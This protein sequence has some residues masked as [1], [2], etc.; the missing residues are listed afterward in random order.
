MR[1]QSIAK[2][3]RLPGEKWK[4]ALKRARNI[5]KYAPK[6]DPE[7][8]NSDINKT[9][10]HNCYTYFLNLTKKSLTE[11][12]ERE[13]CQK[14]NAL[15]PQ[16]GY[17]AGFIRNKKHS[18]TNIT[19]R[20]MKDNPKMYKTTLK[21]DCEP[22][23]YMG[24]LATM[25]GSTYHYYRRDNTGY[26]SHKDGAGPAN[27]KDASGHYILDPKKAARRYPGRLKD[28]KTVDYN[29][30]CGY[31]CVPT[32]AKDKNWKSRPYPEGHKRSR[33]KRKRRKTKKRG[34][35]R[36]GVLEPQPPPQP[37]APPLGTPP[38]SQFPLPSPPPQLPAQMRGGGRKTRRRRRRRKKQRTQKL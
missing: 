12:C 7:K 22:H 38:P 33:I 5:K 25:P 24:S 3:I 32:N 16:P 1:I 21:K 26:W 31:F 35:K 30:F 34:K 10:A 9:N 8:W 14:K 37:P 13:K 19:R 18:C 36:G 27:Q 29:D 28:G 4:R 20:M 17:H 2:L 15:K 23:Y 11:A 6:Y